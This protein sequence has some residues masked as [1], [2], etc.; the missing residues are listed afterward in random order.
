MLEIDGSE[1]EGGGQILRTSIALSAITG[2]PVRIINI[3]KNRTRPGLAAQHITGARTVG[4]L[5]NAELKG[6]SKGSTELEFIPG[7]IKGGSFCFD[8]GTAGSITLVLQ[9]CLPVA[10]HSSEPTELELTGGTDVKFSPPIDYF[11]FVLKPLIEK[12]GG[13]I[14]ILNLKRGYYPKGGGKV[15]VRIQ[16]A[17][18]GVLPSLDIPEQGEII[19]FHGLIHSANLPEHISSRLESTLKSDFKNQYGKADIDIHVES[20]PSSFSPGVGL[21]LWVETNYSLI[22]SNALGERGIPAEDLARTAVKELLEEI[23]SG[24][25][26]DRYAADQ[27]LLYLALNGGSFLV[28]GPMTNHAKTNILIIEKIMGETF[29]ISEADGLIKISK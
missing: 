3:R 15:K 19:G 8:I 26:V 12:T 10:L 6:L 21:S 22:G 20:E 24:A 27:L 18:S 23:R 5:C 4:E 29:E 14:S 9:A 11:R 13:E 25:A 28:R 2:T 17:G 1:G 16:P 7:E